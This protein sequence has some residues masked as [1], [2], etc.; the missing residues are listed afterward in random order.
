[1]QLIALEYHD[2]V[3]A[4]RWDDSGFPGASAAT[5]KLAVADFASHVDAV[6]ASGAAVASDLTTV[7]DAAGRIVAWTFDDGGIGYIQHAADRLEAA[8]WR[9]HVFMT[10]S[11]IDARGF[12]GAAD[13][14]DLHRRGHV[15]GTHSRSHLARLS[16]QPDSVI[17]DEWRHSITDLEDVLGEAVRVGSV[18]GGFHSRRVA[19]LAGAAGLSTLFTSEP[20]TAVSRVSGCAVVG[21]FTLRRGHT[22]S[23]AR[24]LVGASA[25]ARTGQ[26]MQWNAKKVAK[27][28]AGD[29]YARVRERLLG[30]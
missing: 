10:T 29:I 7:P 28:A 26:W 3:E 21:R 12:L 18:P 24:R 15:I 25:V 11:Q 13:L 8:G 17:S 23:Y 2:I 9:G 22:A 6:R 20:E 30:P 16:R 14:R 5:Y 27:A 19:E 1:M 4:G